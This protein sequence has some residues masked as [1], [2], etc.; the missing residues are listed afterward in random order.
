MRDMKSAELPNFMPLHRQVKEILLRR[1]ANGWRGADEALPSEPE[2]AADLEVSLGTIRAAL[3][4][5]AADK[6]LVRQQGKGTYVARH[7]D[8]RILFQFQRLTPDGQARQFPE[9][10]VFSVNAEPPEAGDQAQLGLAVGERVFKLRRTRSF[11]GLTCITELITLPLVLFPKI[12]ARDL[13]NNLYEFYS[14][15]YGIRIAKA[16]EQLKAVGATANDSEHLGVPV[17]TPLLQIDRVA[18]DLSD[19]PVE[20]RISRCRTDAYHYLSKLE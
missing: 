19:R 13:P 1:I 12:E 7:D 6:V 3:G 9:S 17:G 15:H 10:R 11:G 20:R 14:A 18:V 2:L 8:A 4:L 5:L 16:V